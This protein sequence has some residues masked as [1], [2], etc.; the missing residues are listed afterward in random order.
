MSRR[1]TAAKRRK[2]EKSKRRKRGGKKAEDAKIEERMAKIENAS[3]EEV[4]GSKYA[5]GAADA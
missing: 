5:N 3:R 1:G 4:E 2:V